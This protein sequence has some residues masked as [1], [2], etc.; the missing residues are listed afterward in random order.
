MFENIKSLYFIKNLFSHINDGI[1]LGLIKYNKK[2]QNN[3]DIGL[4]NYKLF[5]AKYIIYISK[6]KGKIY[7]ALDDEL[8]FEGEIRKGKRW[9][10]K[11]KEY[12]KYNKII[13]EG[14]YANGKRIEKGNKRFN[15]FNEGYIY[16]R[17]IYGRLVFE[18]EYLKGKRNG[19]GIEYFTNEDVEF[20]GEYLDGQRN[21]KGKEYHYNG[22]LKFEGEYLKGKK[23]DGIEYDKNSNIINEFRKGRGH[24]KEYNSYDNLIFEGE[25][26]NGER[27]GAGKEYNAGKLIFEGGYLNGKRK[28]MIKMY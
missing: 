2:I 3:L 5:S 6:E 4:I 8:I 9:N 1:K 22:K 23:W 28:N 20:E 17:D 11:G 15:E 10:G 21:G 27:N 16:Q 13:F 12:N 19:K 24:I 26:L 14:E 25:Y 7:D 18:G